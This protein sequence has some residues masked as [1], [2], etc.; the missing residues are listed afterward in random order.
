MHGQAH[1]FLHVQDEDIGR[2]QRMELHWDYDSSIFDPGSLCGLFCNDHLYVSSIEV[3]EM[4][5]YPEQYDYN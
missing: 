2:I 4:N 1:F 5:Y 3:S